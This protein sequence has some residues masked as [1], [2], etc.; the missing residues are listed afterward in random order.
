[1]NLEN[2]KPNPIAPPMAVPKKQMMVPSDGKKS[3]ERNEAPATLAKNQ[4][5]INPPINPTVV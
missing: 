1:M 5:P 2:P 3:L 4:D